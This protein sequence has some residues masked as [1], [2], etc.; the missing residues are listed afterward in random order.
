LERGDLSEA[1]TM[2]HKLEERQRLDKKNRKNEEWTPRWFKLAPEENGEGQIWTYSGG[3]WEQRER[4]VILTE[5]LKGSTDQES[6]ARVQDYEKE[7]DAMM[8]YGISGLA[9]DFRSF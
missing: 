8:A 7:R 6:A 1:G 4:K 5:K 9:C 3:Y 2:K